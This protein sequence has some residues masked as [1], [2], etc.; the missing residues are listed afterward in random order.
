MNKVKVLFVVA[1]FFKGGAERLAYEMDCALDKNKYEIF[2][3][4]IESKDNKNS[5]WQ[6][7]YDQK[8]LELGTKIYYI[9]D[10]LAKVKSD[11]FSR[12]Y[13]KIFKVKKTSNFKMEKL[14]AFLSSFDL[15][16]WMG[17]YTFI[18]NLPESIV[19]KS[20]INSMSAKFQNPD[21]YKK[22][23]FDYPYN[24]MSGFSE[25]EFEFEYSQFKKINHWFFPLVLKI[26]KEQKDWTYIDSKVKKIGIFTRLD[27]YKPLDPFFYSFQLLLEKLPNTEL[28]IFGTGDPE[29]EGVNH[30]L[31]NLEL[32]EKVFFRGHQEDIVKTVLA[33]HIDLSWFQGYN[34]DRPAGYAG[35]DICSTGLP[36]LCWDFFE[37]PIT[38]E[39][40]IYPHYKNLTKFVDRS[41]KI[42]TDAEQANE[43]ST[44]QFEDVVQNRDVKKIIVVL[45]NVYKDVLAQK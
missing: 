4:C 9:D 2:I 7:Y 22:F 13:R 37:K 18:P 28:H 26:E 10:F 43:L 3:L 20:L 29:I 33:E 41:V 31:R 14:A 16:H 15:I 5:K 21:L 1:E 40:K 38:S 12:V 30:Y 24:F 34:N 36:L 45:D 19:R 23:D 17:E 27:K 44:L 32:S 25:N 35:F 8:H 42:L 6:R 11:L 39:N